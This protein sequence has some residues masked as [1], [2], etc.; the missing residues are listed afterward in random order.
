MLI[1]FDLD[2][3]LI[4]TSGTYIPF[5]L[6]LALKNMVQAGLN[7]DSE[8]EAFAELLRINVDAGKGK[9]AIEI[10]WKQHSENHQILNIGIQ[11]YYGVTKESFSVNVLDNVISTLKELS[12]KHILTLVS[13]G[14]EQEQHKKLLS[15]G[16]NEDFFKRIIIVNNY[17]KTSYYQELLTEFSVNPHEV[18]VVGDKFEGD[19][20]PAKNLGMKTVHFMHGRGKINPPSLESVD[21]QIDNILKVQEIVKELTNLSK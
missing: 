13:Y 18:L 11:T 15:S 7:I 20:L 21:Y 17:D 10:F 19:L 9:K 4:D 14:E 12:K 1:I 8:E 5:K 3:T 16:I 6:R 2:D